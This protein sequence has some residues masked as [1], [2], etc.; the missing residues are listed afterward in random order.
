MSKKTIVEKDG[1]IHCYFGLSYANYLVVPRVVLQS[2]PSD[3]Q[4]EFVKLLEQIPDRVGI[5]WQ[6]KGGYRVHA[7]GENGRLAKDPYS[8]YERGRRQLEAPTHA[9]Q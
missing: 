4:K 3:W 2:M 1:P 6:P 5:D 9:S 7:V 8:N